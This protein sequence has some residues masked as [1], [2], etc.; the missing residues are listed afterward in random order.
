MPRKPAKP[1]SKRLV[2]S[3]EELL[4]RLLYG[5]PPS[6]A[7]AKAEQI[8]QR[9]PS[10]SA[11]HNALPEDI[12]TTANLSLDQSRSIQ[13]AL[14]ISRR[15]SS[16]DA[17]APRINRAADAAALVSDMGDL[18]QESVRLIL[19]DSQ[20]R[21]I[22]IPTIYIGTVNLSVLRIAEVFRATL[23]SNS[24]ALILVHNHPSGDPQPSPEDVELTRVLLDAGK[25]LDIQVLDHLIIGRNKWRSLREMGLL[26][27]HG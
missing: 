18:V 6:L 5:D 25:L 9:W 11:L 23:I 4:A 21:V 10:F 19:L 8:M 1:R 14:E 3:N 13:A 16:A 22:D 24:P 17:E 15:I 12:A 26:P 2:P 27:F 20:R 7:H